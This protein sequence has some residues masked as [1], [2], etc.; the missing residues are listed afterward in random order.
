VKSFAKVMLLVAAIGANPAG[1]APGPRAFVGE[2]PAAGWNVA[3]L[4]LANY[5]TTREAPDRLGVMLHQELAGE[6]DLH[7]VEMGRV[8]EAL[9]RE[10]WILTD[11]IPPDLVDSLGVRL[12]VD[13]L[14]VGS[15]LAYGYRSEQG[16][17]IPEISLSLRLL[18]T[19]GGQVLWSA[20]HSRDGGD[21]ESV[22]GLG[23]VDGLERLAQQA[24]KEILKSLPVRKGK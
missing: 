18:K 24:T 19:P 16:E 13:A 23:R 10:P 3:I 12:Q 1:C 8:D 21:R 15:I 7:L 6:G 22:F 2:A 9:A 20:V 17:E 4:P 5:T 14:L 11:R